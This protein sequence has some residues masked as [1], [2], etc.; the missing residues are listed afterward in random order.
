MV[1]DNLNAA[2][3]N[4]ERYG[5][6]E[7]FQPVAAGHQLRGS[8]VSLDGSEH[9]IRHGRA[10]MGRV[11]RHLEGF[12]VTLEH[13]VLAWSKLVLVLIDVLR[14]DG[15]QRFF[16]GERVGQETF[17]VGGAGVLRHRLP[18]WNRT[19]SIARHLGAHW[20]QALAQLVRFGRRD[21]CHHTGRQ[22]R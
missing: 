20:R 21:R 19:V 2:L 3:W 8:G 7:V 5:C 11:N 17:G 4:R 1:P 12:R 10:A 18:G 22:Q 9:V 16:T 15:E 6:L 13:R 14:R